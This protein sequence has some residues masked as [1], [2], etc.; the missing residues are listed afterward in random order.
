MGKP[1]GL[2]ALVGTSQ[3]LLSGPWCKYK[4]VLDGI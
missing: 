1:I 3:I 2:C 4:V